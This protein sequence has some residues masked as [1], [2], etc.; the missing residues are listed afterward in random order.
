MI[1]TLIITLIWIGVIAAM[2]YLAIWALGKFGLELPPRVVQ[3]AWAIAVLVIIL[4]LWRA[5]GSTLPGF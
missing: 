1:E 4:I 5:F 3:I 2:V